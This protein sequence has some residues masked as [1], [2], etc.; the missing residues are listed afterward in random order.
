MRRRDLLRL[1]AGSAVLPFFARAATEERTERFV[2]VFLRGAV[3]GLNTVVPSSEEAYYDYR[4]TIAV[5]RPGT[6][7]GAL[8]LDDRFALHPALS[9]VLPLWK[10]GQLAF[11]HAAGSPDPTRSHFDA[12]RYIETGTPGQDDTTD[13][14]MNRLLGVLPGPHGPAEAVG[15]GAVLPRILRGRVP[16][17]NLPLGPRAAAP[18]PIDRPQIAAAFDRL[19][20]G[21]GAIDTAYREGRVARTEL[22]ADLRAEKEVADNGAPSPA[23]FSARAERLAELLVR[24][25]RI[26]LAFADLGG[27]D[28][29]VNQGSDTG[30]LA[31]RLR[32]LGTGLS[33]LARGL[34]AA[35]TDTVVLV[36]SEFGRT[37]HENGNA[38]TD[39]GH[40]NVIWVMGGR[41]A[42]GGRVY[43][44]WPG[45]AEAQ[46]YQ[47]RDLAVTTDFRSV[48]AAVLERHL[49]LKDAELAT[50]FPQA[51]PT[52]R[53]LRK[54]VRA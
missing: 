50:V 15:I 46:L 31:N 1:S 8:P 35:W 52:S 39:H 54:L 49:H 53:D 6:P 48:I 21:T 43:G 2:T 9:D 7:G 19:Y 47:R 36:I 12:Q 20:S 16:V 24:D 30:G 37:A 45:L 26:R 17:A 4:P 38:G 23:G 3:D 5:P 27:W 51:P 32:A 44:E 29:H 13:G 25:P 40:G 28:T 11:I 14:W 33:A 42:G 10:T 41:I 34:G 18:M 22:I